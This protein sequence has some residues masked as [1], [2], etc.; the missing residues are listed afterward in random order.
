M[1]WVLYRNRL[2]WAMD[3]GKWEHGVQNIAFKHAMLGGSPAHALKL[4]SSHLE[5]I[6][7][8][9]SLK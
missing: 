5:T 3:G 4:A 1:P 2:G 6:I 7:Y 8:N 9:L